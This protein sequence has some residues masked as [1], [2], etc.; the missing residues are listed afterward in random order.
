MRVL[1][2]LMI[3][4]AMAGIWLS[5]A[6][7]Q[8]AGYACE[9]RK[10]HPVGAAKPGIPNCPEEFV[11]PFSMW[12]IFKTSC[13]AV[14]DGST[15][16]TS[17]IQTCLDG[18][19]SGAPTIYFPAGNDNVVTHQPRSKCLRRSVGKGCCAGGVPPA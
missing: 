5:S 9:A 17:A 3:I 1:I 12:T 10:P 15:D 2:A 18:L 13:G 11:G 4:G 6:H 14:G 7:A 8:P 16:D 19:N